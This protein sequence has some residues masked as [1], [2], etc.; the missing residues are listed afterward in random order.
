[1]SSVLATMQLQKPMQQKM[2]TTFC[3]TC[4]SSSDKVD[5][6]V[7]QDTLDDQAHLLDGISSCGAVH[8]ELVGKAVTDGGGHGWDSQLVACVHEGTCHD[9][10]LPHQVQVGIRDVRSLW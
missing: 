8:F 7:V 6:A 1:M 2:V 9:E 10:L 3:S 4:I 5:E